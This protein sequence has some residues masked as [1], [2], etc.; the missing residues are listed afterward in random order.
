MAQIFLFVCLRICN[1]TNRLHVLM[2]IIKGQI[3]LS[4]VV[5]RLLGAS[6]N[7]S[8]GDENLQV[9]QEPSSENP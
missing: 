9:I 6:A 1:I 8:P 5:L 7:K 2:P 4:L 3:S